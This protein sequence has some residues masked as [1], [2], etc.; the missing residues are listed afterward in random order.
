MAYRYRKKAECVYQPT[1]CQGSRDVML[2]GMF[3]DHKLGLIRV[4]ILHLKLVCSVVTKPNK[5]RTSALC[6][7]NS[8][9]SYSNNELGIN[10]YEVTSFN[11][12]IKLE[13]ISQ[14]KVERISK[15]RRRSIIMQ[16]YLFAYSDSSCISSN[17]SNE[18]CPRQRQKR[19]SICWMINCN[20]WY[21]SKW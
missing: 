9:K 4:S 10:W 20:L 3:L 2:E 12:S 15:A 17:G 18:T 6:V 11:S 8:V 5:Y 14:Q 1:P 7:I 21:C 19:G 13:N 16:P